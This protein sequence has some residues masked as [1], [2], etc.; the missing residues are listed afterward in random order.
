MNMLTTLG[1]SIES[2]LAVP[3][4]SNYRPESWPPPPDW[5]VVIDALGKV[6]SRWGDPVWRLDPWAKRALTLNFGDGPATKTA[7]PIS[8]ANANLLRII[9]GWWLYGPY[10]A[11]GASSLKTRFD[12]MRRLFVL[13]EEEGIIASELGHFPRVCQRI[14][15]F[16]RTS[17][18]TEFLSLMHELYASRNA[19]GFTLLDPGSLTRLAALFPTHHTAQTPYIPPRIWRYQINRLRECLDDFLSHR[20][21]VEACYRFCFAAYEHNQRVSDRTACVNAPPFCG[22]NM[23]LSGTK[24]GLRLLGAFADTAKRFGVFELLERWVG[25]GGDLRVRALSSYLKLVT[26]A[27]LAY[28]LNFSLMRV[29]EAWNLRA[30]CLDIERDKSFGDIF[31]LHGQTTK[32]LSDSD[33]LWITSPSVAVAVKAMEVISLFRSLHAPQDAARVIAGRYLTDFSYEPWSSLRNKGNHSR[34][35]SIPPYADLLMR[36]GKLFD[37][38]RLRI[39]TEDL[40]LARLATPTLP[41]EYDVGTVWP[42]A[43]H[44]LRRTGAVNMQASGLVSDASL[45]YQ[46]K[47]VTRSMSLYYGQNHSQLRL[48]EKAHTLYVRTMYETLGKELQQLTSERFVSPHGQKRK[49]EIVRLISP[50]DAKKMIGLAKKGAVA[51]RPIILGVCSSREPCPYGGIDNIAHCGGGDSADAKPCSDVLYDSERLGAVDDLEHVLKERLATAQDGSPLMESLMAQQRSVESFR[52]VV[53]S[54]NGR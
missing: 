37:V 7:T 26:G 41:K 13:C 34:R 40:K 15:A 33:A 9:I 52:R 30:G 44:Q 51:C 2:P 45:Q 5:P 53:G 18:K 16:L 22:H 4:A 46:L 29:E 31:L 23:Q 19:V 32:T 28:I 39:T 43:W 38:E 12:Q 24:T 21:Q 36:Y 8:S 3:G 10:G 35:P 25:R 27:G 14:P 11:R 49:A 1:L 42:L 6:I 50:E 20:E 47:H 48:E 17:R 54:A